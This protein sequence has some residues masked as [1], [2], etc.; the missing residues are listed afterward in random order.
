[1]PTHRKR[2]PWSAIDEARAYSSYWREDNLGSFNIKNLLIFVTEP[3]RA[4]SH[5][6]GS[7]VILTEL[8]ENPTVS[9][10]GTLTDAIARNRLAAPTPIA[11]RHVFLY[12]DPTWSVKGDLLHE[13]QI[14]GSS[15]PA[16]WGQNGPGWYAFKL[17]PG[18]YLWRVANL[19]TGVAS[20]SATLY[21]EQE[22]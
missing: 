17:A 8:F 14:A 3:V 19:S 16:V 7:S 2:Q 10:R 11:E 12:E 20:N 13:K 6:A 22:N 1:M 4:L 9:L 21:W 15:A 5:L 18:N